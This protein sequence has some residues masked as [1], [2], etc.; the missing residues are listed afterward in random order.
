MLQL[1][2]AVLLVVVTS[3]FFL[4]VYSGLLN[5]CKIRCDYPSSMP[6][7]TAYRS[8][9]GPYQNC[10]DAFWKLCALVP[11]TTRLFGIYYDD[12][13]IVSDNIFS[14]YHVLLCCTRPMRVNYRCHF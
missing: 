12:P 1:G 10:A 2:L 14:V 3:V 11:K 4:F 6:K 7:R 9:T 8:Y 5:K 13:D